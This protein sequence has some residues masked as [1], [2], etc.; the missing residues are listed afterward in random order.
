M[1]CPRQHGLGDRLR[2]HDPISEPELVLATSDVVLL[3]SAI[4]GTPNVLIEAQAAGIPVV[5]TGRGGV[6][7]ALLPGVSGLHLPGAGAPALADAVLALL[8]DESRRRRMG[9]AGAAFVQSRFG[10]ERMLD[11]TLLLYEG[12]A[13][14]G[15]ACHA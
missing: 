8:G 3:T 10:L 9:A 5:A 1:T 2:V 14:S 15:Q 11:E 6:A 13:H 4:E 7:E 12:R